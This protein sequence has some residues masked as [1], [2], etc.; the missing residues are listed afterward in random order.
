MRILQLLSTYLRAS[1]G[2]MRTLLAPMDRVD[3]LCSRGHS[4]LHDWSH[5]PYCRVTNRL[6]EIARERRLSTARA[7]RLG[8]YCISGANSGQSY[9]ISKER[10]TLGCQSDA[11]IVLTPD[12]LNAPG[13]FQLMTGDR[14]R[15]S[16]GGDQYFKLNGQSQQSATLFDFDEVEILNNRFIVLDLRSRRELS[17]ERH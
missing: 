3:S 16:S 4:M 7:P 9:L 1:L 17:H 2:F 6:N 15:L 5:C 10:S 14:I 13:L 11:D 8:L 12:S